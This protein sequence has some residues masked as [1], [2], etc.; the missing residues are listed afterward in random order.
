MTTK[1]GVLAG[2]NRRVL[3]LVTVLAAALSLMMV[4]GTGEANAAN[5]DWLR[6]DATGRCQWDK[7][8]Y[9]VQR[10]DVWSPSMGKSIPVLVQPAKRGGNAGLYLLDGLRATERTNA[11]V[12]DVNAARLY[13]KH[14]ITLVMPVG[15]AGSFYADWEG[16]ATYDYNNP[17]KYKW[18][19]FLTRELPGYLQRN[20]GVSPTNN[21]IAGL[22]MGGTAAITLAGKHPRQF[23]QALSYSGYLNTSVPGAHTMMRLALLD[24][25]GFNLNAMYGSM[26][27]PRRFE[28]D[29]SNVISG[30]HGT[31][32][33]VSAASG[34]PG[35]QDA[36]YPA[37]L[38]V[39][40]SILEFIAMATTRMWDAKARSQGLKF[41]SRY[42]ATGIHN[43]TQFGS[44]L[45]R[46]KSRVL[47][48]MNAW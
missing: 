20:F 32:V 27:S 47:N 46:T 3:T 33:Y 8:K 7:A 22:S 26:I 13:S 5:R 31:D 11:W 24:S 34:M 36:N 2:F 45:A 10:C 12:K 38:K 30:L 43:W 40:G 25:G 35:P 37:N 41:T 23:R 21:S 39:S 19:T 1:T 15:G 4:V 17:V 44:E 28:N 14:N 29:P 48:E 6:R 18:E 9:W 42:P 16:P